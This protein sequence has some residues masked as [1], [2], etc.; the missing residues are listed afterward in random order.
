MYSVDTNI[1]IDW[2]ERW[3]PP[4]VFITLKQRVEELSQSGSFLAPARVLDEI[5]HNGRRDLQEWAKK[6]E[7][8]FVDHN[9]SLQTEVQNIL[10]DHPKLIDPTASHDEAD[11]WV[12][13]LAKIHGG[14]VV[15]H[16]TSINAK[17]NPARGRLYIPD[18]CH[19]MRIKCINLVELMRAEKWTF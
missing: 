12:I 19:L 15:T 14:I 7:E 5:K 2:W 4:D 8:M 1:F 16:E 13:A 3:Y 11:I 17:R 18:I 9:T 10:R 6:Q